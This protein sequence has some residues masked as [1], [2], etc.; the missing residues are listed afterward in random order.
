[1]DLNTVGTVVALG[2]G[3]GC[4]EGGGGG[5]GGGTA[6]VGGF[7]AGAGGGGGGGGGGWVD[8]AGRGDLERLDELELL[9]WW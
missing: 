9:R 6:A 1:M 5:G 7:S 8:G 3:F 4:A 2:S